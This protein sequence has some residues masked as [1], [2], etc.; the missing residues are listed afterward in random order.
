VAEA[1]A[2]RTKQRVELRDLSHAADMRCDACY[3]GP[4]S[5]RIAQAKGDQELPVFR[6]A[7]KDIALNV[8]YVEKWLTLRQLSLS[9]CAPTWF[10][11]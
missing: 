8:V 4:R 2:P 11:R 7:G 9:W 5:Y 10:R 6:E 3:P 1:P